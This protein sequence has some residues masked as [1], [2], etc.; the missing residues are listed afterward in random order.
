M[1]V[2]VV[3]VRASAAQPDPPG[4]RAL[5]LPMHTVQPDPLVV[6]V[7]VRMSQ[8]PEGVHRLTV[9][10]GAQADGRRVDELSGLL[11]G[12]WISLIVR[13]NHLV[14]LDGGCQLLAGDQLL[15]VADPD[16]YDRLSAIFLG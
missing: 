9:M 2:L 5:R 6:V 13:D 11:A 10:T 14:P 12:A 3:T 1:I 15:V 8:V 16:Q 7:G 4:A